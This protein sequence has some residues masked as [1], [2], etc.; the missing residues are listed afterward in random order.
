MVPSLK[1]QM[2]EQRSCVAAAGKAYSI[3]TAVFFLIM[4]LSYWGYGNLG[5]DLLLD[6]MRQDR[7]V[8]WWA[9]TRPWESGVFTTESKVFGG[10]IA[11]N[12]L[13]TDGMYVPCTVI[14]IENLS[15]KVSQQR[16]YRVALRLFI[17]FFRF[18][19]ATEVKSFIDLTNLT[20]SVFCVTLNILMPLA[21]Y[22]WTEA[23]VVSPGLKVIHV[24]IFAFGFVVAGL[25]SFA[26]ASALLSPPVRPPVGDFPRPGITAACAAAF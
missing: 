8:G 23:E 13:L 2:Q 19:V 22:Y 25:G 24:L 21:A 9:T 18:Y 7:Q 15:P 6:G 16:W 3:C 5:P 17:V 11:A 1:S 26:A 10:L 4:M 12:L 14:A 20:S